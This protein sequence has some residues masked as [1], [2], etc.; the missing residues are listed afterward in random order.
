[1]SNR[2][3]SIATKALYETFFLV[4]GEITTQNP[5]SCV[6]RSDLCVKCL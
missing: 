5:F 2:L 4:N 1:M 6:L 3:S